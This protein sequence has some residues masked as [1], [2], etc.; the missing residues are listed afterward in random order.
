MAEMTTVLPRPQAGAEG[1][2]P[3]RPPFPIPE[4]AKRLAG[5]VTLRDG[6][7]VGVRAIRSDDVARLRA[8]HARL[9]ERT[10]RLRYFGPQPELST[11][12]L[13][14]LVN[15]NYAS[16]MALVATIGTGGDE[17][18]IAVVRYERVGPETAEVAFVVEDG[19]QRHGVASALFGRLVG[20]ARARGFTTL[21]AITL[22]DNMPMRGLLH[23]AGYPVT[24]R[25][26]DGCLELYLDIARPAAAGSDGGAHA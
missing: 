8:F 21:L 9:S 25:Y 2:A 14:R 10:I 11:G 18:I 7:I 17:Q 16:R 23:N 4:E 13:N 22:P 24:A 12:R 1:S 15:V 6:A 5:T 20:Y 3:E 26:V 19:W